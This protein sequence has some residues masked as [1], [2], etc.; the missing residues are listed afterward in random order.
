MYFFCFCVLYLS[1]QLKQ[2]IMINLNYKGFEIVLEA[3]KNQIICKA[4][5]RGE[6][7]KK[8]RF[9]F[10]TKEQALKQFKQTLN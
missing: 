10:Y 8:Q 3:V 9:F 2:T 4:Y 6:I 5:K 7:V 1:K